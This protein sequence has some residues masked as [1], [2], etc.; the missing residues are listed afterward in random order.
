M[1][2]TL[3]L[4]RIDEAGDFHST[5]VA[6]VE[7]TELTSEADLGLTH[8]DGKYLI[9]RVQAEIAQDQVRALISQVRPC[10]CCGHLRS[11]KEHRRRRIDTVFGHLRIPAPR[12]EACGCGGPAPSSP[13]CPLS[14]SLYAET[15][16]FTD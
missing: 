15:E 7:R 16:I 9:R 13:L 6:Y 3:M 10:P 4:E 1:K 14:T 8:D 5:T 11:L 2:W 12:F